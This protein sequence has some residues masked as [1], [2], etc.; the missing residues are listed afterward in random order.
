MTRMITNILAVLGLL[1]VLALTGV[2]AFAWSG[3]YDVGADTSHWGATHA[4][5]ETVRER[6]IRAHAEQ[7]AVPAG[8]DDPARI[9]QGAGNYDAMCAGCHL[10]PGT[11]ETELSRGLYPEPPDLTR[12]A[13]DAAE[14]FWAIKHGIKATGMPA[15]GRSMEDGYIWNMVAFLQ[16]LPRLDA[17]R[18]RT[19]V[20]SSG[21]HSHGGGENDAREHPAGMADEHGEGNDARPRDESDGHH[22]GSAPVTDEPEPHSHPPGTPPHDDAP[23]QPAA[24]DPTPHVD[25]PGTPPHGHGTQATDTGAG[26]AKPVDH[27]HQH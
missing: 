23:A 15:W 10:A 18:Y 5:L 20:A 12:S 17:A 24:E 19:L 16:E 21:G 11:D 8:L 6:S 2:A 26:S 1:A 3:R 14:A 22:D 13:V 4:L 7:V 25:P 27:D 9:R